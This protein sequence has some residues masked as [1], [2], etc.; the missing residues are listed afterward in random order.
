MA[1]NKISFLVLI[2]VLVSIYCFVFGES[3]I[4][5]R[6]GIEN[7]SNIVEKRIHKLKFE[8]SLLLKS[9]KEYREGKISKE[10]FVRSG[11]ADNDEKIIFFHGT[12]SQH[13]H[14]TD[15]DREHAPSAIIDT[16]HLRIL[17]IV[18]SSM[19]LV[20]FYIKIKKINN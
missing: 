14:I 16:R 8:N 19:I 15:N 6:F 2:A 4:L 20:L 10:D 17:W 3:G 7:K 9:L 13:N 18:V 5:E 11:Y 1:K 12:E